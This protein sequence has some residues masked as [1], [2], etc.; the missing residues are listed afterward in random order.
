M[1]D[2]MTLTDREQQ[3]RDEMRWRYDNPPKYVAPWV[4]DVP[5]QDMTPEDMRRR[6]D[7]LKAIEESHAPAQE[8]WKAEVAAMFCC[9]TEGPKIT[10]HCSHPPPSPEWRQWYCPLMFWMDCHLRSE[11]Y[12]P[13]QENRP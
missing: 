2:R 9:C 7:E 11:R 12:L 8:A 13:K 6:L 4:S 5:R 1:V 10:G 3:E